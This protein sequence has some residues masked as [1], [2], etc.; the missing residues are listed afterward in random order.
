MSTTTTEQ[1][2][3]ATLESFGPD[4]DVTPEAT[5]EGLDID[6][7]DMAEFAQVVDEELDVRLEGK[8]LKNVMTVADVIELVK[9][10]QS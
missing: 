6:S 1:F 3:I 4:G 8:D 9:S 10:R 7:L 5:I 2:V